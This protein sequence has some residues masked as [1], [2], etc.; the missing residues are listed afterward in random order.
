V[1]EMMKHGAVKWVALVAVVVSGCFSSGVSSDRWE[2][3]TDLVQDGTVAL[4]QGRFDEAE[5]AY[6]MAWDLAKLASAVDGK[7]CVA[8]VR[9]D[10]VGAERYF[11]QALEIDAEYSHALGNL[12]LVRDLQGRV[13]EAKDLYKQALSEEPENVDVRNNLAVLEYEQQGS[14]LGALRELRKAGLLKNEG[15]IKDN[16]ALL[17]LYDGK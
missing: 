4:E 16:I 12:A 8:L 3:A 14:T 17:S 10:L 1:E 11:K 6:S 5:V 9:G 13:K 2:Q 7:G 15:V